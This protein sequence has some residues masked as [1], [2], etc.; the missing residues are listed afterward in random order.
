MEFPLI[1]GL[2]IVVGAIVEWI[3]L[4]YLLDML[5]NAGA[6]RKNYLGLDI[7]VSAGLSF[8]LSVM[9]TLLLYKLFF[10]YD[11][12]YHLFILGLISISFLGFIDDMLGQRDTLG[13]RGHFGA[14]FR[15]KLTTGGLKAVGG[16]FVAFFIA[17][18]CSAGWLNI[19]LNTL[20]LALFTNLLN[21][22]DLRPGRAIKGW[23]ITLLIV[24][25]AAHGRIDYLLL[26]PLLGAVL[27]YFSYDLKAHTM[28]GDAGSNVLGFALGFFTV[29]SL[30][31]GFRVGFLIF[32]IAMH[33]FTEKF[34]LSQVIEKTAVLR[35]IDQLGRDGKAMQTSEVKSND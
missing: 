4:H 22:F 5:K 12:T 1:A 9:L 16:G 2:A 23:L 32:L 17:C 31:L 3:I 6:V 11:N 21:L 29:T 7:P 19:I 20:I 24:L 18:F 27:W 28:M 25:I 13:F 14:L 8:S 30:S 10:R 26:A 35:F 34:S 15:G 33:I